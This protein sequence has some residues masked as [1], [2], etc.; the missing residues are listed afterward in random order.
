M[1]QSTIGVT[2][3]YVLSN[4]PHLRIVDFIQKKIELGY[5]KGKK[6]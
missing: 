6:R 2:H 4:N 1:K 5:I 3:A